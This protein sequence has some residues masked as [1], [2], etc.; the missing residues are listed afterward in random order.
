MPTRE[1]AAPV[2]PRSSA[3]RPPFRDVLRAF[4]V[5]GIVSF[6][7]GRIAYF[8]DELIAKRRWFSHAEFLEAVALSQLMPGP[9]IGNLAAYLGQRLAGWPGAVLAVACLTV[10]G[11]LAILALAWL[12]FGGMPASLTGP[13]G[14]GVSAASVGLAVAAVL[15]LRG[16]AGG[17]AGAAI[18]GFTFL[19]FGPLHRPI[20]WVLV[21]C[22][23]PA[24]VLAWRTRA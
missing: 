9:T 6:G 5:I 1:P 17:V 18:A 16:G 12:Y 15:R 4:L 24:F 14:R 7:G 2:E 23:P 8:E 20:H 10:P 13:I 3:A 22:L 19:L 21:S 11:G